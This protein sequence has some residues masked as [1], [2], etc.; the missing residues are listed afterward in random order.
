MTNVAAYS[1]T[2]VKK[3]AQVKLNAAVFGLEL[4]HQLLDLA[5]RAYLANGRSNSAVTLTRGL[6]RG[7]GK[8]PWRQKGTGRARVGSSRVPTWRGGGV[9]FGPTGLENHTITIPT[10]MKRQAIRQALSAQAADNK[11]VILEAFMT[12]GKTKSTAEL[13]GKL[14]AT[15]NIML[16]VAEKEP[17]TSRATRNLTGV[18]TVSAKYLNVFDIL[19]ADLII[20][21]EPA[22]EII[23]DWLGDQAPAKTTPAAKAPVAKKAQEKASE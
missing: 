7:G 2:G 19:N 11:I 15:G 18:R 14:K 10:K 12:D 17:L 8:K 6:V 5:Y 4:N 23:N 3:D 1:K 13:F 9:V 16:V 22:L 20:I 21:A